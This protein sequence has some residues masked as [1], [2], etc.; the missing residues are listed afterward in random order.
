VDGGRH[1][2]YSFVK[3]YLLKKKIMDESTFSR[4]HFLRSAAV[5]SV[6]GIASPSL[7]SCLTQERKLGVALVGLG[8]YS[9]T[10]LGRAVTEA[11]KVYL[12][13]VVS[14]T[15]SK[16]KAW[17]KQYGFPEKNIYD[18][19]TFRNIADNPDIDIVYVVTPN[20]LHAEHTITALEAGKHVIC[21]KPMAMSAA[22]S[23]Q[24]I[25]T[26]SKVNRK[27][28][29]GYRMHY[30]PNFIEAKRLGQTE[31]FGSVNYIEAALGYSFAPD[32]D[33]WKVRKSMGG[34]SLY[35]LG[36]YPIQSARHVKG[37]EPIFVT[38][39][40]TTRR[41]DIFKEIDETFTWQLE[42]SDGTLCNSYSGPVA[43]LDRLFAGCTDGFIELNP[44]TQYNGVKGKST[45]GEFHF[46]EV[47]Q[48]KVQ[49]DDFA[50][51]V[52]ENKESIVN[53][54]EGW[55]DMLIVDAIH[56]AIESGKREKIG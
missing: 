29:I 13:G 32:P 2:P 22:E 17:S 54:T 46:E 5:L 37:S 45:K 16:A 36:V 42:W 15:P 21:E 38:A 6:A 33:S 40:A 19:K 18:Y 4:R 48:Q 39:Q 26:A 24:M 41:K 43:F 14:G 1:L 28:A 20:S 27:L 31:A 25:N 44:A 23:M 30:D 11:D 8:N 12:A 35:N 7:A 10:I 47:F 52:L 34:G 9:T 55:K 51:C 53:G 49:V 3:C 56:K 50:K